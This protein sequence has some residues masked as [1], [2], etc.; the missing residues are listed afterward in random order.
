MM[1]TCA[2][3]GLAAHPRRRMLDP[4]TYQYTPARVREAVPVDRI[5]LK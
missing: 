2:K 1:K 4:P 3:S 5:K